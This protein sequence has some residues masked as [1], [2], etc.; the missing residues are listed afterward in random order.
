MGKSA[1][2]WEFK[3]NV[4]FDGASVEF[5]PGFIGAIRVQW[6]ESDDPR[7]NFRIERIPHRLLTTAQIL[8]LSDSDKWD[9]NDLMI[10][11]PTH[12]EWREANIL[13]VTLYDSF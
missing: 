9:W 7:F 12:Q 8:K 13:G 5:Y 6:P 2:E 3:E 10:Q 1:I 11:S 4:T